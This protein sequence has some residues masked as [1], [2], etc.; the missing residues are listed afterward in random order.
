MS[1]KRALPG[2]AAKTTPLLRKY[3]EL[4]RKHEDLVHR[5]EARNSEHISTWRL[6]SWGLE[7]TSSGLMLLNGDTVQMANAR[8]HELSRLPG[9]WR[10]LGGE[11]A[12][13][14]GLRGLRDAARAEA[15]ALL[16]P[17]TT[18]PRVTRYQSEEGHQTLEL[19]SERVRGDR[20]QALVFVMAH[21]ITEQV[22]A[23][24]ELGRARAT[25]A[26]HEHLRALGKMASGVAHDLHNTLAAMRLRLELIQ[27]DAEFAARQ[28][29]NLDALV[30][31]VGDANRRVQQLKDFA[32][33]RPEQNEGKPVQLA[34]VGQEAMEIARA[35][36]EHRAAREG[37]VLRLELEVPPLPLVKGSAGDL[38]YVLI[39]LL[40][41][42]RDAMPRG[43]TIRV[44]GRQERGQAVLTVEDEG[45]GIPPQHLHSIFRPFFT[46][47]GDRGTG[48]GLA[49][50]YGVVSRAGG[51]ITAANRPE[52]GAVFTL[53]F[54][55]CPAV[56]ESPPA[57]HSGRR[58]VRHK[59]RTAR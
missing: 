9:P 30:S 13:G 39:N 43:G 58:P 48:L 57:A 35:D 42:A 23:E 56:K 40:L 29:G 21:D 41:N 6:S 25:L 27:N 54:P 50:A 17:D 18:G 26:E 4:L 14:P 19:R 8:W 7:T 16:G 34:L 20:G 10:R 36:L 15:Q 12:R 1:Q 49:M 33:Q 37:I 5:L 38:R 11:E 52:G 44:C 46:T 3:Q 47:K 28:Q 31:I 59:A 53:S 55:P 32:R 22:R 45:T 2:T 24:A 51:T